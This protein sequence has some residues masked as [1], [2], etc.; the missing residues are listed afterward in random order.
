MSKK[1]FSRG[2]TLVEILVVMAVVAILAGVILRGV[3]G[4]TDKAKSGRAKSEIG[5]ISNIIQ[6]IEVDTGCWPKA[7]AELVCK[8]PY[9]VEEGAI[10]NEIWDLNDL[11]VGVVGD[12]DG[13]FPNW[14]GPYMQVVHNDPWGNPYFFDTDYDI[15]PTAGENWAAVLGSFGSNGVQDENDPNSDDVIKIL[16][17]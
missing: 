8:T 12:S 1:K 14:Q 16:A 4:S 7:P 10:D 3:L 2:F 13:A 17:D 5:Q 9:L 15:D 6:Q 11:A